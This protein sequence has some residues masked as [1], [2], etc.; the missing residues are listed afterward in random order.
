[1]VRGGCATRSY[2]DCEDSV[3]DW[4]CG[5]TE[6]TSVRSESSLSEVEGGFNVEDDA[7]FRPFVEGGA[8]DPGVD[9]LDDAALVRVDC[10]ALANS[11][12]ILLVPGTLR[13]EPATIKRSG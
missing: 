3:S 1:M 10:T 9:D 4:D 13:L 2:D 5:V 7:A 6:S 12:T 11:R 8:C